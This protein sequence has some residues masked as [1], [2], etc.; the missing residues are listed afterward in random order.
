MTDV[1]I[2]ATKVKR[3]LK[4][5]IF[6]GKNLTKVPSDKSA[7]IS[8]LFPIKTNS[9]W[10]T[11]FELLNVAGLIIGDNVL[12]KKYSVDFYFFSASGKLL[13]IRSVEL[14]NIGRQTTSLATYLDHEL[15]DAKTFAVFHPNLQDDFDMAGSYLAER[16]YAGYEFK[17]LGVKGY[18][19]GNLDA[20]ALSK[21]SIEPLGQTSLISRFYTVQHC[22]TGPSKYEFVFT[23]PTSR[24]IKITPYISYSPNKWSK[25]ESFQIASLGTYTHSVTVNDSERAYVRFKSRLSL[26]RPVVFRIAN[27]S[28]D[29]FH[30]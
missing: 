27:D 29:V 3:R 6:I 23:N 24:K 4:F 10:K 2:R 9:D 1:I 19:H 20:V 18:V 28:M 7:V 13:G 21:G 16:G 30:G 26:A 15:Q 12:N 14:K 11:E 8:D 25:C 22:L 17:N 5:A